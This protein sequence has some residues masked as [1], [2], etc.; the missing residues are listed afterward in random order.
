[1][2]G[3]DEA[4]EVELRTSRIHL[5][6]RSLYAAIIAI[7]VIT[8]VG[9]AVMMTTLSSGPRSIYEGIPQ[10][11]LQND[12]APILGDPN[13]PVILTEFGDF[14]DP[15]S[16]RFRD[17]LAQIIT[18]YVTQ[19]KVAVI[20]RPY[21]APQ[22]GMNPVSYS[23][24]ETY[25]LAAAEAALCAG[26]QGHFW[27]MHDRLFDIATLYGIEGFSPYAPHME[28]AAMQI[29]VDFNAMLECMDSDRM[30]T[31]IDNSRALASSIGIIGGNR[32]VSSPVILLNGEFVLDDEGRPMIGD[33]SYRQLSAAIDAI[34]EK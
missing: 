21:V 32:A 33:L 22:A 23:Y 8:L 10:A 13:A 30:L 14:A 18:S 5:R 27:E 26:E 16:A 20:F 25:S 1:M 11:V 12:G 4:A 2:A 7:I 24:Y 19:G 9:V 15:H 31:V 34:L 17:T 3:G 28:R 29:G 6:R